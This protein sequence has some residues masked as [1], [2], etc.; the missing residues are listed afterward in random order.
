MNE[1]ETLEVTEVT[2]TPEPVEEPAADPVEDPVVEEITGEDPAEE[3][4]EELPE[5]YTEFVEVVQDDTHYF[6]TTHLDDYT[7]TEGLLLL[8]LVLLVVK[9]IGQAIKEGFYWLL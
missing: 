3:T 4:G 5:V 2:N 9:W 6:M 8:I 1:N 7:V